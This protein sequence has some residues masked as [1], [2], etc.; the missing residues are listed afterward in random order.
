METMLKLA[1]ENAEVGK[2]EFPN[3]WNGS[4]AI[5]RVAFNLFGIDI[6]WYGIIIALGVILAFIYAMKRC[7]SF[8]LIADHVFDVV[9]VAIIAGF[10]GARAYYCIF[11]NAEINFFDLRNGGLAIYGGII[12][13]AIAAAVMCVVRKVKLPTLFDLGG[14]GLL[15]G[16]CIGRWGNF[17]NQEAYGAPTA[18]GLPW[19]M[20][21]TAIIQDPQVVAKQEELFEQGSDL[22]ALVHPCF[23]YESLWCLLGF[24][25]L[26]FYS[27]KLR[28]FDGEIF[29]LYVLWYGAGRAWIEGLRT[30]SLY[31]GDFR[32]SQL[33][34]I[35]SAAVALILFIYFKITKGKNKDYVL[36]KDSDLCAERLAAYETKMM[37]QAEKEKAKKAMR[38][39]EKTAPSILADDIDDVDIDDGELK[40][41]AEQHEPSESPEP[42]DDEEKNTEVE[43]A[44][45]A[46]AAE[47]ESTDPHDTASETEEE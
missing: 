11:I 17:V 44:A 7:K 26:H 27:K 13:A 12:L 21:G 23:L 14:L 4:L 25:F 32:V 39:A 43:E 45:D 2:I 40:A 6:Y 9:F 19:G 1:A 3:L 41:A 31:I 42:A 33:V 30:D 46:E 18:G 24:L 16:Q 47:E 36:Y 10:I 29:L 35:I 15:I 5:D 34:A 37:V 20:T 28:T 22:Y 38:E 8:G